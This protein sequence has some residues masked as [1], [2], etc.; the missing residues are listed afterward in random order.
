MILKETFVSLGTFFSGGE[1]RISPYFL[2]FYYARA[3]DACQLRK[4]E[5]IGKIRK[6]V[7]LGAGRRSE[8]LGGTWS[9][10]LEVDRKDQ[11]GR[12][13]WSWENIGE[14]RNDVGLRAGRR[15]ERLGRTWG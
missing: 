7:G 10:E 9:W 8:R 11:E 15:S 13:V 3:L 4:Q 2:V 6:D 1:S 12:G 14:I 5:K